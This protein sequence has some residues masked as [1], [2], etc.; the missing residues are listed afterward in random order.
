MVQTNVQLLCDL[1][2]RRVL[3][4]ESGT[5]KFDNPLKIRFIDIS[6][7]IADFG[8]FPV[9]GCRYVNCKSISVFSDLIKSSLSPSLS[10]LSLYFFIRYSEPAHLEI[11]LY[12]YH[13]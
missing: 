12:T 4:G 7:A 3:N 13:Q 9:L 11:L 10:L 2:K 8:Q 1:S 6:S 5:A